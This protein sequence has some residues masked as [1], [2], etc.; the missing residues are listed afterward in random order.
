MLRIRLSFNLI[1]EQKNNENGNQSLNN[2][3]YTIY[4]DGELIEL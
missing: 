1:T 2:Y 3:K 4:I